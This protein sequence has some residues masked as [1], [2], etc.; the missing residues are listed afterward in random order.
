MV[1]NNYVV[2]VAAFLL[3]QG[4]ARGSGDTI[5][6]GVVSYNV[7]EI[8]KYTNAIPL[9]RAAAAG[10]TAAIQRELDAGVNPNAVG[11]DGITP[12]WWAA[13]AVNLQGF[14]YLLDH[15]AD[16]NFPK[17]DGYSIMYLVTAMTRNDFLEAALKHGGDPNFRDPRNDETPL[18]EA[19]MMGYRRKV[20]LLLNSGA[21]INAQ[22]SGGDTI[23]ERAIEARGDYRLVW[24]FLQRGAD[25]R[26]KGNVGQTLADTIDTRL[27]D[28][29]SDEY[30][31]RQRVIAFLKSKGIEAH[32]PPREPPR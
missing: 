18:F 10:E 17:C 32:R 8:F 27:I 13:G 24:E 20:D 19:V 7:A 2:F 28:P 23:L 4:C 22:D 25:Y 5:H 16:P 31:W 11:R 6:V 9:A 26:L 21:N 3:L 29:H 1:A 12:L 15:G 14:T 30:E